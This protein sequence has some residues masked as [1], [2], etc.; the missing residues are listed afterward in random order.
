[1][2]VSMRPTRT[3]ALIFAAVTLAATAAS[4]SPA[5]AFFFPIPLM[6]GPPRAVTVNPHR[7]PTESMGRG[8]KAWTGTRSRDEDDSKPRTRS[9]DDD[10]KPSKASTRTSSTDDDSKPSKAS[11]RTSSKD[12]DGKGSSKSGKG[13]KSATKEANAKQR[14]SVDHEAA[15]SKGSGTSVQRASDTE[16]A[17]LT[18]TKSNTGDFDENLGEARIDDLVE[19]P[20]K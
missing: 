1:M 18:A 7:G 4:P 5:A 12:D 9:R 19:Q 17:S 11:T 16:G 13:A 14:R 15:A 3:T 2:E 10:S 20:P 6:L 8:Y